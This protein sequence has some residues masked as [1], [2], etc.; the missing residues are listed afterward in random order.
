MVMRMSTF[1]ISFSGSVGNTNSSRER[2]RTKVTKDGSRDTSLEPLSNPTE[3]KTSEGVVI[4][5]VKGSIAKQK[6]D[7][8]VNTTQTSLSLNTGGVSAA[9][10]KVAGPALQQQVNAYKDSGKPV[11]EGVMIITNGAKLKCKKVYHVLCCHWDGSPNAERILR[12]LMR[13]CFEKASKA[14][15]LSIAFPAIGTGGLGFPRDFT[16]KVMYEEARKF[17][18]SSPNSSLKEIRFVIYEKDQQ[19]HQAFKDVIHQLTKKRHSGKVS[20]KKKSEL[21]FQQQPP[22]QQGGSASYAGNTQFEEPIHG[23]H[24][25]ANGI[26]GEDSP[27]KNLKQS[28]HGCQMTIGNIIVQVQAG[29][30][31]KERI[32]AIVNSSNEDLDLSMGGVSKAIVAAGGQGIVKECKSLGRQQADTVVMTRAAIYSVT[33]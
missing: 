17:S 8:I 4:K 19:T 5:L 31:T 23:S 11:K 20:P 16:A 32:D 18:A 26:E 24:S 12:D 6:T 13:K 14:V 29:D 28:P 1:P 30:I 22:Y 10:C 7:I 21:G 25:S 15:M 33:T 2:G 3:L 9:I 27:Y